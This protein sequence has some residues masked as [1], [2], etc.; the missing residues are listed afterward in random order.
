MGLEI[1]EKFVEFH[2]T[3]LLVFSRKK[4]KMVGKKPFK[5]PEM[6]I[7]DFQA[8]KLAFEIQKIPKIFRKY[9]SQD[10]FFCR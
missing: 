9:S 4:M 2:L 8:W 10:L 3:L 6:T 7:L 5:M 1:L